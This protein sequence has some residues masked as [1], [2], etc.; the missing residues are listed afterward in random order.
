M[1]EHNNKVWVIT[2]ANNHVLNETNLKYTIYNEYIK[3]YKNQ[4][5]STFNQLSPLENSKNNNEFKKEFGGEFIEYIGE[6]NLITNK[7]HYFLQKKI[8]PIFRKKTKEKKHATNKP[9]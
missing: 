9:K 7:F 4:Q 6:Y 2:E 3:Y 1:I 5:F 8:I